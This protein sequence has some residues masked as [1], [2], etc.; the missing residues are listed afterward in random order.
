MYFFYKLF[1]TEAK[2]DLLCK[3]RLGGKYAGSKNA[4]ESDP[5]S[6]DVARETSEDDAGV[7]GQC[8]D[9]FPTWRERMKLERLNTDPFETQYQMQRQ[10]CWASWI[11]L[12]A[13][14][15]VGHHKNL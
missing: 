6:G 3:D 7:N 11:F 8:R 12:M 2:T 9:F 13:S 1:Y 15:G 10:Y 5:P 14:K 4:F